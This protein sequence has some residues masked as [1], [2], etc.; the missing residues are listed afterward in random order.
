MHKNYP[1]D[2]RR[3]QA[4]DLAAGVQLVQPDGTVGPGPAVEASA[5]RLRLSSAEERAVDGYEVLPAREG[6]RRPG[7][8][9]GVDQERPCQLCRVAFAGLYAGEE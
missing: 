7:V 6:K 1:G 5:R 3:R 8:P 2:H 9:A 4:H